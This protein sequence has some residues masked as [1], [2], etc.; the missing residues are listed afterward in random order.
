[1]A[2]TVFVMPNGENAMRTN[3]QAPG[4]GCYATDSPSA[5]ARIVALTLVCD[6]EIQQS[7]L[8]TLD[9]S[10]ALEQLGL[11]EAEFQSVVSDLCAD[12]LVTAKAEGDDEC[13][14]DPLMIEQWMSEVRDTDLRRTVLRLCGG[15][16]HADGYVHESESMVMLA[17]VEHRGIRPEGLEAFDPMFCEV[18]VMLPR[19]RRGPAPDRACHAGA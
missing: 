13:R 18:D 5:G 15:V 9:Q 10:R 17:A 14:I 4:L 3:I 1:M 2:V 12:L 7:E 16:I 6:G 19:H 8:D 11:T